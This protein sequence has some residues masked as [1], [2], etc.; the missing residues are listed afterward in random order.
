MGILYYAK[1]NTMKRLLL[2]LLIVPVVSFGQN[3]IEDNIDHFKELVT[4]PVYGGSPKSF[5][6]GYWIDTSG[7]L[8]LAETAFGTPIFNSG[9]HTKEYFCSDC[10]SVEGEF[11]HYNPIFLDELIKTIKSMSPELKTALKPLYFR[12]FETP[13]KKLINNQIEDHFTSDCNRWLL[14]KIKNK[15]DIKEILHEIF[16]G[17]EN[18]CDEISG[19]TLFW[20]RRDYDGTSKQFLKLFN[21]IMKEFDPD[22]FSASSKLNLNTS[23]GQ[24]PYTS[25]YENGKLKVTGPGYNEAIKYKISAKSGLNLRENPDL[26]SKKI[27]KIP[28]TTVIYLKDKPGIKLTVFDT[29]KKTGITK[30]IEGEWVKI[31]AEFFLSPG[32]EGYFI[33]LIDPSYVEGYVFDG[34]IEKEKY[35]VKKKGL[36]TYYYESGVI[37]KESL[38]GKIINYDIDGDITEIIEGNFADYWGRSVTV[39]FYK[40]GKAKSIQESD[41][42]GA[43]FT[44]IDKNGNKPE[45]AYFPAFECYFLSKDINVIQDINKVRECVVKSKMEQ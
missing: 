5:F 33:D 10:N 6:K 25:Y 9:P 38:G 12:K 32:D 15:D 3:S 1:T 39:T 22:G 7:I 19:E 41:G 29:D 2:L 27:A 8:K 20:I 26:K 11:G 40:N 30:P 43:I 16:F 23:I 44:E 35:L 42:G 18:N 31:G 34:F 28:N 37:K 21:L 13:L 17:I 45:G 4:D 14:E 36:W 24:S